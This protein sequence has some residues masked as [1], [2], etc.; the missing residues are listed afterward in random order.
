MAEKNNGNWVGKRAVCCAV[1]LLYAGI[2]HARIGTV[3]SNGSVQ[4]TN[5]AFATKASC[6]SDPTL[7]FRFSETASHPNLVGNTIEV[8]ERDTSVSVGIAVTVLEVCE[9]DLQR[10]RFSYDTVNI[11]ALRGTDFNAVSPAVIDL[12]SVTAGATASGTLSFAIIEGSADM[13]QQLGVGLRELLVLDSAGAGVVDTGNAPLLVRITI[14]RNTRPDEPE[15][16]DEVRDI[17]DRLD[18]PIVGDTSG[19]FAR[20]CAGNPGGQDSILQ[21]RCDEI[22]EALGDAPD[23]DIAEAVRA[24]VPDEVAVQGSQIVEVSNVQLSNIGSRLAALRGGVTGISVAGLSVNA[25]GS[26]GLGA[27]ALLGSALSV[28]STAAGEEPGGGLLDE[29]WGAFL[30][31][32]ISFGDKSASRREQG[33]DFNTQGVTGGLDYRFT[34]HFVAG[35]G[36]GYSHFNSDLDRNAGELD[37][38]GWSATLYASYFSDNFYV[39]ASAGYGNADFDQTRAIRYT[40]GRSDGP[41]SVDRTARGNTD[42]DSLSGSLGFGY[43]FNNDQWSFGP[44]LRLEYSHADIDTFTETGASEF[45]LRVQGRSIASFLI[46]AGFSAAYTKSVSWGVIVPQIEANYLR[47]TH[48]GGG[49]IRAGLVNDSG[50]NL[51]TLTSD[52]TDQNFSNLGLSVNFVTLSGNQFFVAYDTVFGLSRFDQHAFSI[53]GRIE[54]E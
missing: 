44:V 23:S 42:T 21:E 26:T 31:G 48:N 27:T 53:G 51:F 39:D 37:T 33:F 9:T 36:F 24:F 49:V 17:A 25:P 7:R 5:S 45:N 15:T 47:D 43:Q 20:V 32:N 12:S 35:L 30:T 16:R 10:A 2:G 54:F 50:G 41:I 6:A 3:F 34:D 11:S 52:E 28:L 14:K 40:L 8:D 38:N 18:D 13:D 1:A 22:L 4:Y 19:A 29:R 46:R